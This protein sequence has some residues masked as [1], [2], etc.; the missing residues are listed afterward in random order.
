[1][2]RM[3]TDN[4]H[5]CNVPPTAKVIWGWSRGL[6]SHPTRTE[7]ATF[8]HKQWDYLQHHEGFYGGGGV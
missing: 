2:Y 1:M 5:V 6:T 7:P 3:S 4:V 8:V